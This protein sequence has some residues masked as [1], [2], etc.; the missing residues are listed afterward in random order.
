M[1]EDWSALPRS[2]IEQAEI[3]LAL[4]HDGSHLYLMLRQM[5]QTGPSGNRL[6]IW[7]DPK[8]EQ[9]HEVGFTWLLP[10]QF[11]ESRDPVEGRLGMMPPGMTQE[12]RGIVPDPDQVLIPTTPVSFNSGGVFT[13]IARDADPGDPDPIEWIVL[14][15]NP[16]F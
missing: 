7:F 9:K 16:D 10:R 2:Y 15:D 13:Y 4:A 1:D 12:M 3:S 14:T 6:S 8:G 11:E 5:R